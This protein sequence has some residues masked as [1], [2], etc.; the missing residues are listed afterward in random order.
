MQLVVLRTRPKI[1]CWLW[2][3]HWNTQRHKDCRLLKSQSAASMAAVWQRAPLWL[4]CILLRCFSI[5]PT[6]LSTQG[7]FISEV[8]D[9]TVDA[10]CSCYWGLAPGLYISWL[11]VCGFVVS[12]RETELGSAFAMDSRS[13]LATDTRSIVT[14]IACKIGW[15]QLAIMV[16][17]G[18]WAWDCVAARPTMKNN[19]LQLSLQTN[20][21]EV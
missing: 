2:K 21:L 5:L 18:Q 13:T 12:L 6:F 20:F 1:D 4:L 8:N 10:A 14:W 16:N 11:F 15:G 7:F 19:W 3:A 17:W 9:M